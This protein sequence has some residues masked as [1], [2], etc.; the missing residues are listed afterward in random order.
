MVNFG[1]SS[2]VGPDG[3]PFTF[4]RTSFLLSLN[5]DWFQ[6]YKHTNDSVGVIYLVLLN[7]PR[8]VRYNI[9]N[10]I[11]VGVIPGPK[12]PSLVLNSYLAPLVKELNDLWKYQW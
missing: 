6:P 5:V 7:L 3:M 8:S 9:E 10:V 4:G 1:K 2:K 12:E 11:L